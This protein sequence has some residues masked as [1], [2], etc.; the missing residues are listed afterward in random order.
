MNNKLKRFIYNPNNEKINTL[1]FTNDQK[2]ALDKTNEYNHKY[3][4][5]I[6]SLKTKR[7]NKIN[8]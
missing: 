1:M 5:M 3:D 8:L 4:N 2:N 6:K 7:I